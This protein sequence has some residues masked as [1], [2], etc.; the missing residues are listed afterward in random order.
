MLMSGV[1]A[2][3]L[4]VLKKAVEHG[5]RREDGVFNVSHD[6]QAAAVLQ[7]ELVESFRFGSP[8]CQHQPC[9]GAG[10][11]GEAHPRCPAGRGIPL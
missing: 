10:W 6:R 2:A 7:Q 8:A 3:D 5:P 11:E 9:S 4:P 1:D